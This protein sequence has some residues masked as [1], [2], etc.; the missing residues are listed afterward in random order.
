MMES[1]AI[2]KRFHIPKAVW[3]IAAISLGIKLA[4]I[5]W[6]GGEY[7]DGIIQL[8]LWESP[9]FFF[10]PGYTAASRL[11]AILTG[12]LLIAGRLVSI[13][14]SVLV[15]P[16][17]YHLSLSLL[18][19]ERAAV[20]ATLFLALSPIYNRWSLR[21][22]TDSLF[23]LFFVIC[24]HQFFIVFRD[25]RRSPVRLLGWAGVASLVRYQGFVFIPLTV[26]LIWLRK[27]FAFGESPVQRVLKLG[28]A[29]VPW[30]VLCVW[31]DLRGFGHAQQ[32]L[33]RA[34]FGFWPTLG[35][36]YAMLESY[37]LYWPWASTYGLTI[38]ACVG[39][40]ALSQGDRK[41]KGFVAFFAFNAVAFLILQSCFLSFQYRYLLP[42]V[43][44][45]CLAG[46]KGW[47]FASDRIR[48]ERLR[49][50][51]FSLV[52]LNLVVMSAAV[53][54]FQ[55]AAFADLAESARFLNSAK[56]ERMASSDTRVLSDEV[57]REGVY[58]VKMA[59][60]AAADGGIERAILPYRLGGQCMAQAGDV[61]ILHKAYSD[62]KA[63]KE[64][65]ETN[66]DLKILQSWLSDSL[67]GGFV[68]LPLLPDIMV[69]PDA[70]P[71]TSNP[72]CTG[73]RFVPQ[74]YQSVALSLQEKRD[75]S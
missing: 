64:F 46:G 44:L 45:W 38:L 8:K 24:C 2:V 15:L 23:L 10:P 11:L 62:L 52:V 66:F 59:F 6:N 12:D 4:L 67:W 49:K 63:E 58:N 29:F 40:T 47:A 48:D 37:I 39:I 32:I 36:Y 31:I 7:T 70:M 57:Y 34:T 21:V 9:V 14:A 68:T 13:L 5:R 18:K 60:W 50:A 74:Y 55:R 54:Y 41:A 28:L 30:L 72:P 1:K 69:Y 51:C 61:V 71:L 22:M 17:F 27:S 19:E 42:L 75:P 73:F 20:W 65:L 3:F 26:Y 43:P 16:V 25:P 35:G 53:L 33:D 56:F